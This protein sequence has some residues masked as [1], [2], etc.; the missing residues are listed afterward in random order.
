MIGPS[1]L[2]QILSTGRVAFGILLQLP[3]KQKFRNAFLPPQDDWQFVDS[4]Y[5]SA[6][7]A[8]MAYAAGE[9]AFLDAIKTG[10]DLHMMSARL[11]YADKWDSIAEPGCTNLIDGSKCNCKE[12]NELRKKSKALTFGLA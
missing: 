5:Q 4:D 7:V 9:S 8:I 3:A 6:E 2:S 1:G 11:M 12:H 10:K